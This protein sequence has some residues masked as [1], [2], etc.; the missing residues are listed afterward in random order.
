MT[1]LYPLPIITEGLW[2]AVIFTEKE[3]FS[4]HLIEPI[5]AAFFYGFMAIGTVLAFR[6]DWW[7]AIAYY[8]PKPRA[9]YAEWELEQEAA[10]K[11]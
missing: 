6:C 11:E 3:D 10:A 7:M 1:A 4:F 9:E 2:F 5:L 8:N